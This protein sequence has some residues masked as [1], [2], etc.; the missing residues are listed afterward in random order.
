M[1]AQWG[2]F[3]VINCPDDL[4]KVSISAPDWK[5]LNLDHLT[6]AQDGPA[7]AQHILGHDN[8]VSV[9]NINSVKFVPPLDYI[10]VSSLNVCG[11]KSKFLSMNFV[12][13][14]KDYGVIC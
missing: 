8:S 2:K 4:E 12:N 9:S 11:I 3:V 7:G 5:R 1:V 13:F 14:I 10:N 6:R